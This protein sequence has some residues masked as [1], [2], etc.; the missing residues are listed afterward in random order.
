MKLTHLDDI[1]PH[2]ATTLRAWRANFTRNL[3]AVRALGH[4]E[5][6]V[7]MWEFY[8]CYCEVGFDERE[9][10]DVHMLLAKP[11]NRRHSLPSG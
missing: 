7:R 8:L 2:Y 5:R 3:D 9:L 10:G 4:S 11:G 6:F 1:G